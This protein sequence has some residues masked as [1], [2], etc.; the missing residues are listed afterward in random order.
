MHTEKQHYCRKEQHFYSAMLLVVFLIIFSTSTLATAQ[1]TRSL[2]G[3]FD[4]ELPDS[5]LEGFVKLQL[6]VISAS[7]KLLLTQSSLIKL[8]PKKQQYKLDFVTKLVSTEATYQL[9][10]LVF[11]DS[12]EQRLI[13][14]QAFTLDSLP[15][16]PNQYHIVI[17]VPRQV[18]D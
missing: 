13:D 9:D 3:S 18:I 14:R 5:R 12:D 11:A 7:L 8:P 16:Q 1:E 4:I 15:Q 10:V 17:A 6:H 2:S